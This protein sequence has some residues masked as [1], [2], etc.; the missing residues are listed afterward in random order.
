MKFSAIKNLVSSHQ[1][2][3]KALATKRV[4]SSLHRA[5]S[6]CAAHNSHTQDM[7]ATRLNFR[8]S[9]SVQKAAPVVF[10]PRQ[11]DGGTA[12]E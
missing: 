1:A 12:L 4:A 10:W 9:F 3:C 7:D 5:G 2:S 8:S 11:A 6:E